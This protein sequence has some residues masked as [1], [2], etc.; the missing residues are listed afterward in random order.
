M[1][2]QTNEHAV[3]PCV[4]VGAVECNGLDASFSGGVHL[5]FFLTVRLGP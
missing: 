4:E 2:F 1:F 3:L 5:D